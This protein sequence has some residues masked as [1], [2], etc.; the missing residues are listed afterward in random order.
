MPNALM[1]IVLACAVLGT[2]ITAWTSSGVGGMHHMDS[3][4]L[5]RA[6]LFKDVL[7]RH[8]EAM[9]PGRGG[10]AGAPRETAVI[11]VD[12]PACAACALVRHES[13]A[14]PV[15][16]PAAMTAAGPLTESPF[17]G[18]ADV[19]YQDAYAV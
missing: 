13:A 17:E 7:S 8:V 4:E 2:A 5:Q 3:R 9:H 11:P 12:R 18:G 15:T 10:A 1:W 19:H 14:S 16:S 6:E